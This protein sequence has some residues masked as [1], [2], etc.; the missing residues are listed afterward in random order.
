[1]LASDSRTNAGVDDFA[2]LCKMT[3]FER[4]G[5]RVIILLSSGNLAGT[6]ALVSL[7]KQRGSL[8]DGQITSG[9]GAWRPN[10]LIIDQLPAPIHHFP[11]ARSAPGQGS[12]RRRGWATV[13]HL[14]VSAGAFG[15][16]AILKGLGLGVVAGPF[17]RSE[18]C[19]GLVA[20][21][22]VS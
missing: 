19:L 10:D 7:L 20:I 5:D 8:Q 2:K 17:G 1:M 3:C 16:P 4:V 18:T 22:L 15:I 13:C 21:G 6:Q 11:L 14:V 9:R 12:Q